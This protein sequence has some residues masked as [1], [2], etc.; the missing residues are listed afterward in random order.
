VHIGT[1][2]PA[3]ARA[4]PEHTAV[5]FGSERLDYR[6]FEGRAKRAANALLSLGVGKGDK[7]ATVLPNRVELLEIYWA[8][9]LSGAVV[10]PLSPMLQAPALNSLLNAA[11]VRAVVTTVAFAD[12]FAAIRDELPDVP[13]G[14]YLAVD[15]AREGFQSYV[16]LVAA[17]PDEAPPDPGLG[18]DDFYDI[19]YSSGTTGE[20]KGIV[21]TH[22]VRAMYAT[23]FAS[24]FRMTPE[25]VVLHAGSIVFNGAFVDLMPLFYLG[26]TYVLLP[27]FDAGE[28]IESIERERVSHM[29]VVPSQVIALL[30]HPDFA[31][32]RLSSL[33]CICCLGAPLLVEHKRRLT[34]AL[35]NR[36]YELYGLTEG[37]VTVLD[38]HEIAARPGSVGKPLAFNEMKVVDV[39]G[40]AL[41]PGEVGEICGKGPLMMPGYYKRPDL[42]AE[43]VVDGWLHT[44]DVGRMDEDGY[45]YLADRKKDM[46]V[47]G[48]VNVYPKDIEEVAARHPAVREVS[49]FGAPDE[50]WGEA[51]VAAVILAEDSNTAADVSPEALAAWINAR[52]G[53]KF[54]RVRE[55]VVMTDFP[56]NTAG[57]TLKRDLREGYREGR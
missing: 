3:H 17:A 19:V 29:I 25:S 42:T 6:A 18:D 14:N 24:A 54:Q 31:P 39:A 30:D 37:F 5:V 36:F 41:P 26:G 8:V 40:R 32:E 16:D 15:E 34:E 45:L 33:E 53:A 47:S 55:V 35:P 50:K 12:T 44:G 27:A 48:G 4:R 11:D 2:I 22:G 51:P 49:V 43:A 13:A 38:R 10:V 1:L 20:P 9:T 57:K 52:V 23:L 28:V 56:R 46:I 21:H 7:V